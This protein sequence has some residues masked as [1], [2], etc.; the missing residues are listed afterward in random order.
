ML[1]CVSAVLLFYNFADGS[2]ILVFEFDKINGIHK[3]KNKS[4][5]CDKFNVA[6]W[7]SIEVFE[8]L[9]FIFSKGFEGERVV[10]IAVGFRLWSISY[11]N[12][13]SFLSIHS[14]LDKNTNSLSIIEREWGWRMWFNAAKRDLT[15]LQN[16]L[17]AKVIAIYWFCMWWIKMRSLRVNSIRITIYTKIWIG[18]VF[19]ISL[20]L[21][22]GLR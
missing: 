3:D 11:S 21:R 17:L 5:V 6:P 18:Q 19:W 2:V 1:L 12:Q 4:I 22:H 9:W 16:P 8:W 10:A 7:N 13:F 14:K 15:R 20:I